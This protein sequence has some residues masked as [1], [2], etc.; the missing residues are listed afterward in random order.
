MTDYRPSH[1]IRAELTANTQEYNKAREDVQLFERLKAAAATATK[2][3]K[4]GDELREEL[5]AAEAEEK[6]ARKEAAYANIRNMKVQTVHGS[7]SNGGVLAATYLISFER[8][9]WN[10]SMHRNDWVP[11]QVNGFAALE[12]DQMGY[13]LEVASDQIPAAIMNL[14]PGDPQAAFH[15]Y[16]VGMRRGYLGQ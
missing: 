13:L 4:Q 11:A 6:R 5:L 14:A 12:P 7:R 1:V 10:S 8:L 9:A 15:A 16:A 3:Q 2:L